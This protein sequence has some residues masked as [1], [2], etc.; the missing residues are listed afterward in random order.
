M[1][2]SGSHSWPD[3][4]VLGCGVPL[5]CTFRKVDYCRI[6]SDVAPWWSGGGEGYRGEMNNEVYRQSIKVISCSRSCIDRSFAHVNRWTM[7]GRMFG[8]DPDVMILR[9]SKK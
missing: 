3:K 8:N 2:S 6:G 4:L 1:G 5:A 9:H 7:S